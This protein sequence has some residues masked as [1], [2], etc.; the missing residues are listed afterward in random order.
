MY[1]LSLMSLF[2]NASSTKYFTQA[3][4][5]IHK[6]RGGS[7]PPPQTPVISKE[8]GG[9]EG[10]RSPLANTDEAQGRIDVDR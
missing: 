10:A 9:S 1:L 5:Y 2:T 6:W 8:N 7:N 4:Q 3:K